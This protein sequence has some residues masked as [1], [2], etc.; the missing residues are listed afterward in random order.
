MVESF[1]PNLCLA[2]NTAPIFFGKVEWELQEIPGDQ[3]LQPYYFY[4]MCILAV[5]LGLV[6][7]VSELFACLGLSV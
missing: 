3:S 4:V 6:S 5:E 2:M 1:Q 7:S